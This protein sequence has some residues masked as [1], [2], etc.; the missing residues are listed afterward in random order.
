GRRLGGKDMGGE[1]GLPP[2]VPA[3]RCHDAHQWIR[4]GAGGAARL[5]GPRPEQRAAAPGQGENGHAPP[6]AVGSQ[7]VHVLSGAVRRRII[8][9][10][11]ALFYGWRRKSQVRSGIW[12]P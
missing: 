8:T 3:L 6:E 4:P 12:R 5:L 10:V 2:D 9:L 11:A 1:R 7:E